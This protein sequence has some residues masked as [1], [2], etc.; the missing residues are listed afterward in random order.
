MSAV[1]YAE[2]QN[3]Y[4]KMYVE[5]RKYI[6]D[7]ATV[8]ALAD[9]EIAIYQTCQDIPDVKAKLYRL[10]S[11][12]NGVLYCDEELKRRLEYLEELINEDH[13]FVKLNQV[14]EVIQDNENQ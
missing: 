4:N 6:W 1:S 11:L 9:L 8:A 3:A 10:K 2:I 5:I 12:L 13:I 7:F 14:N